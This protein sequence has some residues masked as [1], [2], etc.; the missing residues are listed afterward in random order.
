MVSRIMRTPVTVI[1]PDTSVRAAASLMR[2]FGIGAL[3]VCENMRPIGIVT[4][5]DIVTRW[6]SKIAVDS[7][8]AEIMTKAIVTCQSDQTV[9]CAAHSMANAQVRRLVVIDRARKVVGIITLGDIANDADETLAG[10]TLG[11]IV[12]TR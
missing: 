2:E 7:P 8:V 9:E 5:R 4:D 10:E 1:G 3:P 6:V 11:E 12:E